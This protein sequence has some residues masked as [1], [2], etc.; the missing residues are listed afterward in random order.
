MAIKDILKSLTDKKRD[1]S[2]RKNEAA[3]ALIESAQFPILRAE[4]VNIAQYKR[5]PLSGLAALGAAF[6]QLPDTARTMTTTVTKSVDVQGKLFI[7]VNPKGVAGFLRDYGQG[8]SG[9]IMQVNAQGKQVIAGR[10]RFKPVNQLSATETTTTVVPINPMTMAIAAAVFSIDQKL[11]VLQQKA[12]EILQFLKREKQSR[13]RGN[14]SMLV[15]I[16]EEYKQDCCNEKLCNLRAVA[17]QN[18]KR[19]AHQDILFYQEQI[20]SQLQDQ[21]RFH[22]MQQVQLLLSNVMSEFYEYQLACY[23]YGFSS[24]LEVML[25]KEFGSAHLESVAKKLKEYA[26]QYHVLYADCHA[27][28]GEYQRSAIEAKLLGSLGS[29]AKAAGELL[30]SV[31]VLGNGPVDDALGLLTD[32][33]CLY[34]SR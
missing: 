18:I 3:N 10:M 22:G 28:I 11:T 32:G 27:Q 25:Q 5:I 9:N 19:E 31:P 14:L 2:T 6:V 16:L 23:L 13:Q 29:A 17:V 7:G 24:F 1:D 15:E 26:D 12:E 33:E 34:V 21:H 8:T 20:S 4:D 30:A